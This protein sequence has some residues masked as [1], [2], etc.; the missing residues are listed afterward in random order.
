MDF[1]LDSSLVVLIALVGIIFW[2]ALIS[3]T[4]DL[5]SFIFIFTL[6]SLIFIGPQIIILYNNINHA[7]LAPVIFY[8]ALCMIMLCCGCY[9]GLEISQPYNPLKKIFHEDDIDIY[10]IGFIIIALFGLIRLN[11]SNTS[12]SSQWSGSDVMYNFFFTSYRYALIFSSVGYFIT[13]KRVFLILVIISSLFFVDRILISGRRTDLVYY[14][15]SVGIPYLYYTGKKPNLVII[16]PALIISFQLLSIL[17]AVRT[18]TLNGSGFGS[19]LSGNKLPSIHEVMKAKEVIDKK[20]SARAPE[21]TACCYGINS[22]DNG[23]YELDYGANYWNAIIQDF[24]PSQIVGAEF[25]S[26]L[27]INYNQVDIV[28]YKVLKGSTMTGFYDTYA[29]F[30][31][32]GSLFFF[33]LGLIM[34]SI[35]RQA[36][37]GNTFSLIFYL[38][39]IVD[40]LHSVT[41]RSTLFITGIIQFIIY[42]VIMDMIIRL[43]KLFHTSIQ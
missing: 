3:R 40:A 42:L 39:I 22:L 43:Y 29:S 9:I 17:V 24:I 27:K 11:A 13:R 7:I 21:L 1:L 5:H 37:A 14:A 6:A 41:H 35:H 28:G 2:K 32:M 31:L 26:K 25:K 12:S 19:F 34:S 18:V 8:I 4:I 36:I 30:G 33:L 10:S 23:N 38:A 15:I 16:I 20:E